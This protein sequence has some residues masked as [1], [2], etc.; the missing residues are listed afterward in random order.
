M[1]DINRKLQHLVARIWPSRFLDTSSE[2]EESSGAEYH[3]CYLIGLAWDGKMSK[4][5]AKEMQTSVQT[6]L[7]DFETRIRRD[8]K[9]YDSQ[10]C[11]MSAT[12]VRGSELGEMAVDQRLWGEFAGDT[13]DEDSD[14]ELEE[15]EELDNG[16]EEVKG[17]SSTAASHGSRAAVVGKAPGLGKFRTAADVLNRLRWDTNFDPSDYIIGYEDR[18]LGARERAVEQWKSEQTDE[19]FIPQHRILYFKRRADNAVVWERRTRVDDIFGSG[20][21]KQ[22]TDI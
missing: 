5:N 8:E 12:I 22:T 16:E 19:E 4:E 20:I 9:Y 10:F 7:Q 15:G 21:K 13:D 3:G 14:D 6:V 1:I 2:G 18:F 17:K 11:W